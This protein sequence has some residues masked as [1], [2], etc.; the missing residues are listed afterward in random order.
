MRFIAGTARSRVPQQDRPRRRILRLRKC[1]R[2]HGKSLRRCRSAL[3]RKARSEEPL[4]LVPAQLERV[5]RLDLGDFLRFEVAPDAQHPRLTNEGMICEGQRYRVSCSLAGKPY[6]RPFGLDIAFADAILGEPDI[7]TTDDILGFAG[8]APPTLRIYSLE[9]HIAEKLHAYTMPRTRPNSR[10]KDLPYIAL[11]AGVREIE[12]RRLRAAL[13]Q[14][15]ASRKM[16]ALPAWVPS[17][18]ADWAARYVRAWSRP[19]SSRGRRS[20][21]C[22]LRSRYS[23][24]PC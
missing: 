14:T 2:V 24:I 19:R 12:G 8:I 5:A 20:P 16:Q 7:V 17:P 15:F 4:R 11:L 10:R 3:R 6:A 22:Y 18:P 9:T 13:E 1:V 23:S 21:H